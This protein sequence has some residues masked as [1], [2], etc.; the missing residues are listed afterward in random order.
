MERTTDSDRGDRSQQ[1]QHDPN[2][3][4]DSSRAKRGSVAALQQSVGNQAVKELHER[5]EVQAKLDVS[6]PGD[7]AERE[8]ERVAVDVLDQPEPE[9]TD[10]AVTRTAT[11]FGGGAVDAGTEAEIESVTSGGSP[12]SQSAREFF[13]PRFGRDFSDV[14]V[15]TGPEAD[16]AAR[17]I[18]AE[19]FT[20]GSDVVFASNNYQPHTS[21]G[22][23]LLAHELT[24]VVQ[25]DG[26]TH[27][28]GG[29]GGFRRHGG[30]TGPASRAGQRERNHF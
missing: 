8:A 25:Q 6:Q 9:R 5:G 3:D 18:D 15:H 2:R 28:Q 27:R 29:G 1:T 14:R 12:L 4:G 24:H 23:E 21:R 13:E 11:D 7:P 22:R 10:T 19:A 16:E 20:Y 30:R 17:S 26:G